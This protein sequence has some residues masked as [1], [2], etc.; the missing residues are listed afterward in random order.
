MT[1]HTHLTTM[2]KYQQLLVVTFS[3]SLY[4]QS[5]ESYLSGY[6]I[7]MCEDTFEAKFR[8]TLYSAYAIVDS[9][10]MI[11]YEPLQ[12]LM[13]RLSTCYVFS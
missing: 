10:V 6:D 13:N 3:I 9:C 4:S 7:I 12:A 2:C 5:N 1:K 8:H 11:V